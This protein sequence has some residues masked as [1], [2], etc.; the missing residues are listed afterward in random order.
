MSKSAI[1]TANTSTVPYTD[2]D[3]LQ[4]GSIVRRF[5]CSV[6]L[7]GNRIALKDPG[8][9]LVL[10]SVPLAPTAAGSVTVSVYNNNVP[11]TG[12][13]AT[14]TTAAAGDS[15]SVSISSVVRIPCGG[16]TGAITLAVSGG[17]GNAENVAV[18]VEKL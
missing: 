13:T 18:T 10:A 14:A 4:L 17:A 2:G 16:E 8:Y 7:N 12:A 15:A 9:Y 5:G 11:V 6:D 1:Y 3:V